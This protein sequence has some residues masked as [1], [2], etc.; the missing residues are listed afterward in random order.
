V[1]TFICFESTFPL[2]VRALVAQGPQLLVN[3]SDDT[4]FGDSA[5]P[6]QH[7]AQA[8]FRA[9]ESRRDLVRATGSGISAF[10]SAT[11]EI[12]A[13]TRITQGAEETTLVGEARLANITS[14]YQRVGN[15]FAWLCAVT[16]TVL[17]GVSFRGAAK[18]V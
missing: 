12:Q 7:L 15:F 3:L 8:V 11:G 9:I 5:E 14:W 6:E 10:V 16:S 17:L 2:W 4:W 1:G 13:S 18:R